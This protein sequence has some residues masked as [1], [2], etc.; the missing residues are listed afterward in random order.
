MFSQNTITILSPLVSNALLWGS[1]AAAAC[2]LLLSTRSKKWPRI[3]F[4]IAA[5]LIAI[6]AFPCAGITHAIFNIAPWTLHGRVTDSAGQSY[7][8]CDSSFLQGQ[9]MA[10]GRIET[11]NLL[12]TQIKVFGFNNGDSPRSWA[13]V[14]RPANSQDTYG[15]L[16]LTDRQMLVGVRYDNHCSLAYN[17]V[18]KEFFGHGD[19]EK[20]SPFICLDADDE[21]HAADIE[22]IRK[23]IREDRPGRSM[24]GYP[25]RDALESAIKHSNPRVKAVAKSLLLQLG[26]N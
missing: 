8:F 5:L 13:S 12:A 18:S 4:P 9:M 19:I 22:T 1:I 24:S 17:L 10:I 26:E 6:V 25:H 7:V 15:Q 23:R 11:G 2:L 20:S 16:Y 3:K 21:L 14:I